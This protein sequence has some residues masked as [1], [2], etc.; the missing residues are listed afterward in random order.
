[1]GKTEQLTEEV[2]RYAS[3][4][5]TIMLEPQDDGKGVYYVARV[6]ELPDL[7]M[8]GDTAEEALVE[9]E[10]VKRDWIAEY[11]RLGNK[12]PR[13]LRSRNYSGK[14]IV[15]MPPSLHETLT[16]LAEIER[17]SVNQYMVAALALCAG[18]DET[19]V[20]GRERRTGGG[21]HQDALVFRD[22]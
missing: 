6:V 3:L 16:K 14:M 11:L 18:R 2:E 10:A 19:R 9:L 15:R 22:R 13:P 12:M 4:P 17:V 5:Y 8:T 7:F 21:D 20:D 1:M